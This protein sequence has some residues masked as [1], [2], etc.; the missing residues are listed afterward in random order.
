MAPGA[1]DGLRMQGYLEGAGDFEPV[2]IA[3]GNAEARHLRDE[4]IAPPVDDIAVPASLDEGDAPAR[5]GLK[6]LGRDC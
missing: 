4:R 6:C 3:G 2:D 1:R 5:R